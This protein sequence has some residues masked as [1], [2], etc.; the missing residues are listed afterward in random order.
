MQTIR[1]CILDDFD[2]A[3]VRSTL[4]QMVAVEQEMQR[5]AEEQARQE[6]EEALDNERGEQAAV[7]AGR[8]R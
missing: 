3:A 1:L 7:D 4:S 5:Q 6:A 2:L 8:I